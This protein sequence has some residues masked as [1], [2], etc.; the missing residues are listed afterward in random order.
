[1]LLD[2]I[3]ETLTEPVSEVVVCQLSL[4]GEVNMAC[5]YPSLKL[6]IVGAWNEICIVEFAD[7]VPLMV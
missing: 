3:A 7:D 6:P 2:V 1:M 5:P 4:S